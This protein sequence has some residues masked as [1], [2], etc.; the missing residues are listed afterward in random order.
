MF[1]LPNNLTVALES[2]CRKFCDNSTLASRELLAQ[3]IRDVLANRLNVAAI[4]RGQL[5]AVKPNLLT[6]GVN[7]YW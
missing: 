4:K 3:R 5:V 6:L 2:N 1:D 7:S